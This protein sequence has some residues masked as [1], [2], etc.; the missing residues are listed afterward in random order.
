MAHLPRLPDAP[1]RHWSRDPDGAC[2]TADSR[3]FERSVDEPAAAA[4][5][6]EE[7]AKA[8]CAGC[9]VRVECRRQALAVREPYGVWGG[10]SEDERRTLFTSGPI[11]SAA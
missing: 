4:R 6:R 10:L 5:A 9:D 8:V 11:P 2:R 7:E 1:D 3:V